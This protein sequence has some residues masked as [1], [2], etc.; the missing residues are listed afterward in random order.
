MIVTKR[1]QTHSETLTYIQS[2]SERLFLRRRRD[3]RDVTKGIAIDT[4]QASRDK[5][6]G[7]NRENNKEGHEMQQNTSY[8]AIG[9]HTSRV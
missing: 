7:L 4:F 2:K 8:F 9:V 3:T 6:R 1:Q 5:E